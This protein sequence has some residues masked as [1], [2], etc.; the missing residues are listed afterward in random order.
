MLQLWKVKVVVI[1]MAVV[2]LFPALADCVEKEPREILIGTAISL[3]GEGICIRS[4]C[5]EGLRAG[6]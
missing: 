2:L 5:Q 4:V 1:L 3:A 6:H